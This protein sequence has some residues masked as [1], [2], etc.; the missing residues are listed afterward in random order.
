M[1]RGSDYD[2]LMR[3]A[4]PLNAPQVT[5]RIP[6][7]TTNVELN[8]SAV[9]GASAYS[10]GSAEQPYFNADTTTPQPDITATTFTNTGRALNDANN[11][12]Y[13][14]GA[15]LAGSKQGLP[16]LQP[17]RQVHLCAARPAANQISRGL[18]AG[19]EQKGCSKRR[20]REHAYV[21]STA[22][23]G[24]PLGDLQGGGAG[25]ASG[26]QRGGGGFR[27][28]AEGGQGGVTSE[29]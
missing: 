8:W 29:S 11:L 13:V 24:A 12:Y 10:S 23:A 19:N 9:T 6:T 3:V 4:L 17:H 15:I 28:G 20:T 5:I 14:V 25:L 22:E 26:R 21:R 7:G 16:R 18:S 27:A 2:K 1:G